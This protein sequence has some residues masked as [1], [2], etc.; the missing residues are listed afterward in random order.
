MEEYKSK[1][2][3]ACDLYKKDK[4]IEAEAISKELIRDF[5]SKSSPLYL[6]GWI[7]HDKEQYSSAIEC[8]DKSAIN[9]TENQNKGYIYYA[10][11]NLYNKWGED[12]YDSTKAEQY[13]FKAQSY[14]NYPVDVIYKL[15]YKFKEVG[16][17][18]NLLQKAILKFPQ[19][20]ELYVELAH[21]YMRSNDYDHV[22][23]VLN[24][25]IDNN[26]SKVSIYYNIGIIYLKRNNA[27]FSRRNFLH[28]LELN[29][30]NRSSSA[31]LYMLGQTYYIEKNYQQA[32]DYFFRAFILESNQSS[33]WIHFMRVVNCCHLLGNHSKLKEAIKVFGINKDLFCDIDLSYPVWFDVDIPDNIDFDDNV[34]DT[35]KQLKLLKYDFKSESELLPKYTLINALFAKMSDKYNDR[36]SFLRIATNLFPNY[37]YDFVYEELCDSYA[38]V[39]NNKIE[40]SEN[41]EA[42]VK[43][44]IADIDSLPSCFKNNLQVS[45]LKNIVEGLFKHKK[46]TD[47]ISLCNLFTEDD[48]EGSDILFEYAYALNEQEDKNRSKEIYTKY[49]KMN[50]NSSAALNNIANI[51]KSEGQLD[52]AIKYYK[53]AIEF[54][55]NDT[56]AKKNLA[57]TLEIKAEKDKRLAFKRAEDQLFKEA[58]SYLHNENGFVLEKLQNLIDGVKTDNSFNNWKLPIAKWKFAKYMKTDAQKAE[59][60][61]EQ[62]LKKNYILDTSSRDYSNVIIYSINPYLENEIL[63]IKS[64]I[65]PQKWISGFENITI[66]KLESF[67]YFSINAK[68]SKVNKKYKVL[69]D[70]DYDELVFNYLVE[71]TKAVV[72]LSGSLL[73][74]VLMYYCEKKKY[75]TISYTNNGKSVS[76][77]ISE[78]VLFDLIAFAETNKLFNSDFHSL[79][80]LSRIYRNFVHPSNEFKSSLDK[81][82]SDLCFISVCEILKQIF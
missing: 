68:I 18:I 4:L 16:D 59:S 75:T 36:L 11:G 23:Q 7:N 24:D 55:K 27:E 58:I 80:N 54:D 61:K 82:K 20:A 53:K 5:P 47:I 46:F 66:D 17:R 34:L 33:C 40:K 35:F 52:I 3:S 57:S 8:F 1:I 28:A 56:I 29:T 32:V 22:L 50:P 42:T 48:L 10:L 6:L 71:N 67:D 14:E 38:D 63:N 64:K 9:D 15:R 79:G 76:K 74:L 65:I 39:I 43:K 19:E 25:A 72:I 30:E 51:L 26:L 21:L 45:L 78:V 73:E 60:L 77:K 69:I 44:L 37:G 62:W 12:F 81:A 13:F 70:R 41:I 2:S 31:I 49:I